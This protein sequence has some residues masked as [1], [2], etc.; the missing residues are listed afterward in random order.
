MRK[1]DVAMS[2]FVMPGSSV[3]SSRNTLVNAGTATT[4]M[5]MNT[6]TA[7]QMTIAG[8]VSVLMIFA[9]ILAVLS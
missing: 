8:Y 4:I 3:P 5:M 6:M 1:S 2:P 7:T 9:F